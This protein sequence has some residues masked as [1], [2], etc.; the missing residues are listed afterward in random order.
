MSPFPAAIPNPRTPDAMDAPALRWG[1][2]GTGWVAE[3]FV[4]AVQR[5][6]RQNLIAVGSRNGRRSAD[7]GSRHG[8]PRCYDSY[9]ALVD[10]RDVDVVYIATTHDAHLACARLVLE[11]DKPVLVEKPLGL[12][13]AQATEIAQLAAGRGLFCM[14]ALWTFFLPKADI[15]RQI[16]E[17]GTLGEVRTVLAD[18]GEYFTPDHRIM[19]PD[20]AGGPLLDLGTYPISFATSVLGPPARVLAAGQWHDTGVNAQASAILVDQRGNQAVLHTTLLSNT[21]TS[22]TIAGT[23]GTLMLHGPFYQP[24]DL[25]LISADGE[26]RL[27]F[28]EPALAHDGLYFEAAEA[29]RCISAGRLESPLR[30]LTDSITTME[31]IDEIRRQCGI[32]FPVERQGVLDERPV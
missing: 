22:A 18:I 7:F 16:L 13:A 4:G 3:R 30:P 27:T 26:Q 17:A 29:A 1:L 23:D 15:V 10:D 11:A 12:N 32:V 9:E 19:R 5:R 14:E 2:L 28:T 24:G 25:T 8:I 21:P 20:Q 31:V 6:T